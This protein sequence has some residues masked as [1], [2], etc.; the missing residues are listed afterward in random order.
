LH[1]YYLDEAGCTGRDLTNQEQPIFVL[2]GVSVRDEGWNTTQERLNQLINDYFDGNVPEGFE[3]HAEQLLSPRGNGPFEG[4][5]RARRNQLALQILQLLSDRS[6]HVHIIGI[7]KQKVINNTCGDELPYDSGIPYLLAYDYMITY[8]NWCVK[9]KLGR[10]ARGMI[11][12]DAKDEFITDI[13]SISY[14]RRFT[15]PKTHRIKWIVEFS[16]PVDSRKNPMIQLSD[17]IV[18]CAKK[19]YEVDAGY[20]N[21]WPSEAKAFYAQ[22]YSIIHERIIKKTIVERNGRDVVQLNEYLK[23]VCVQPARNW[24]SKYL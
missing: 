22:C 14:S 6:H 20:R 21:N 1:F 15:G 18:F 5:D 3:L 9:E 8:I 24:K 12:L 23:N 19:F 11:I 2:G 17:L 13:E 16:Y 4:H 10:S 7:D